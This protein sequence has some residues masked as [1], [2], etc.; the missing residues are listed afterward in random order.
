MAAIIDLDKCTGCGDCVDSCP[1]NAITLNEDPK[2]I[3]DENECTDC[4][5]CVDVCPSQ[6]ISMP[7]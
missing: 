6:A 2:A 1:L 3:V 7:Q 4:G 5:T